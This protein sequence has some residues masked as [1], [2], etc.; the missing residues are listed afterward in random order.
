MTICSD[1]LHGIDISLTHDYVT[2]MDLITKMEVSIEH[3]QGVQLTN[4][5]LLFLRTP[6]PV[7]VLN[8]SSLLTLNLEHPTVLL[9]CFYHDEVEI[10]NTTASGTFHQINEIATLDI[11]HADLVFGVFFL[12]KYW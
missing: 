11:F 5:G 4:R 1:T 2:E 8:L 7:L 10:K 12:L 9:F 6:G 3:L